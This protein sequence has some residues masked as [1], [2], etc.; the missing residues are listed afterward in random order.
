MI[1]IHPECPDSGPYGLLVTADFLLRE[2]PDDEEEEDDDGE[3]NGKEDE[4][5]DTDDG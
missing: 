5:E 1:T 2:V 4:E 3:S